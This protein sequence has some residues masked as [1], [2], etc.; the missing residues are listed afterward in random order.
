MAYFDVIGLITELF[1][2]RSADVVQDQ[3]Q[4]QVIQE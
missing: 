2:K 4:P 3:F 1:R